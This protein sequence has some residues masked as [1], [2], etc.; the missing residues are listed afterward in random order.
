MFDGMHNEPGLIRQ[1]GGRL[2]SA[3]Q[4]SLP[5]S[6]HEQQ[7]IPQTSVVAALMLR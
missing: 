6:V 5:G 3:E 2:P 4:R 7:Q 1:A